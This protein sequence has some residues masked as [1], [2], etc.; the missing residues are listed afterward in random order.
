MRGVTFLGDR[1]VALATFPDPK[2]GPGEVVLQ[3]KASGMCGT[4]LMHYRRPADPSRAPVVG[5][6]EPCG[7]IAEVGAGVDPRRWRVGDRVMMHHYQGCGTC[8]HC[9]SGWSQLCQCGNVASYGNNANGGHAPYLVCP[10]ERLVLLPDELSF[11]AGAAISCGTGTAFAALRRLQLSGADTIAIFGQG[12]VGLS[13]TQFAKAFGARVIA[14]DV[15]PAR[16]ARAKE[17]GADELIDP[18]ATDAV[19]A[20]KSLTG[21]RGAD[22]AL[23]TSAA[24]AAATA[25]VRGTRIWGTVCLIMGH[26]ALE[27]D[28]MTD[29]V[30]RQLTVFGHW[31]FSVAGQQECARYVAERKIDVDSIFTH[32]WTLDQ[33]DEAYRLAD[34]QV[35]GKGVFDLA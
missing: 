2:P 13:G 7:V 18:S 33:A 34:A 25:A 15:S 26:G 32:H 23:E 29:L 27:V 24:S 5:G 1:K 6:H 20:I 8:E 14:L 22:M 19:A 9:V 16:L 21:G 11:A 4:D 12:P 3:M 35:A 31:T 30:F 28:I 17:F 10:A